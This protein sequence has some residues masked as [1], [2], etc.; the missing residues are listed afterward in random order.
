[1]AKKPSVVRVA[2]SKLPVPE[3]L[4]VDQRRYLV[5]RI[6]SVFTPRINSL[7]KEAQLNDWGQRSQVEEKQKERRAE[8]ALEYL[9]SCE[10]GAPKVPT[11]AQL[12]VQRFKN[13]SV[14]QL[15]DLT[16][17]EDA[18]IAA[19]WGNHRSVLQDALLM[20]QRDRKMI[21]DKILIFR[22]PSAIA[23]LD[24]CETTDYMALAEAE[25]KARQKLLG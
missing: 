4:K 18:K 14:T 19:R 10:A 15:I 11:G 24:R 8:L 9:T 22:D 20:I 3:S 13:M 25:R 1:M 7:G 23:D 21:A 5:K 16:P 17:A 2:A 6:E 12:M